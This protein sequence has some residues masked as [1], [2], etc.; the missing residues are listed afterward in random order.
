M[1]TD[2]SNTAWVLHKKIMR[3]VYGNWIFTLVAYL[4]VQYSSSIEIRSSACAE[5]VD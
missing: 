4:V 1:N 5:T 3:V 2:D